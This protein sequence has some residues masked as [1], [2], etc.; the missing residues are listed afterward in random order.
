[1]PQKPIIFVTRRLPDAVTRRLTGDYEAR[2]N[3]HDGVLSADQLVTGAAGADAL[4]V[5]PTDKLTAEKQHYAMLGRNSASR[6]CGARTRSHL[7][8][9]M[10]RAL[11]SS[12]MR[13]AIC[14]SCFSK[15]R[16]ASSNSTRFSFK[17]SG[18]N[19]VH[20]VLGMRH[21]ESMWSP[22]AESLALG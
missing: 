13:S 1:M 18:Q 14:R 4:L 7:F 12:T 11:P 21:E 10:T 22:Q 5:T 3:E 8:T 16:S 17:G 19:D 9:A 15:G 20:A 6:A 2:L